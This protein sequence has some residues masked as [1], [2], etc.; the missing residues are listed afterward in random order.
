V[1]NASLRP[2][3][4]LAAEIHSPLPSQTLAGVD[5]GGT[6]VR[7]GLVQDGHILE[8]QTAPIGADGSVGDVLAQIRQVV[9]PYAGRADALGVGVPSVV[10]D[11][12]VYDVQNIPSWEEVPVRAVLEDA[13]GLPVFVENDANC[14]ALGEHRFGKGQGAASMAGLI[15]GT[16]F[17][18]GLVLTGQLYAGPH[19]GAGEVGMLP[20]RESIFEH[21]CSGQFFE[22]RFGASG[23]ALHRRAEEGDEDARVAFEDFGRHLGE[24]VKAVLYAY[25]PDIIVLGGSVRNAYRFFETTM[26]EQIRTFAYGRV[27]RDLR[28][29]VSEREDVALLGAAALAL[30]ADEG[31]A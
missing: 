24:G 31:R 27:L 4:F 7:A 10:E 2:A 23:A 8:A 21:Y 26:R 11:G 15:V 6:N 19:C 5:L 30:D 17:A 18:A 28:L 14:F 12:V 3:S 29:E 25:D 22:R 13:F 1:R 16:G 20:Y 9:A